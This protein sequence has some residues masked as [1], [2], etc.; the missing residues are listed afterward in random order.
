MR[1]PYEGFPQVAAEARPTPEVSTAAPPAAFGANTAAAL[2]HLGAGLERSGD[3]LFQRALAMQQ[4]HNQTEASEANVNFMI[5]AGKIHADY[6]ALQGKA[7]VDAYPKYAQDLKELQQKIGGGLSNPMARRMYDADSRSTM[8]RTI[9]NG[10]GHAASQQK[11]WAIGTAKATIDLNAKAAS[12]DPSDDVGFQ[13]KLNRVHQSTA[14]LA[15][16]HGYDEGSAGER[17]MQMEA[18]SKLWAQRI[19]GMSRTAPFEAAGMLDKHAK[20]MT[21]ADRLKVDAS[22]RGSARAVGS[23]NIANDVYAAGRET[24]TTPGKT[25]AQMEDE[26]R[27]KAKALSPDD[28]ILAQHAVAALQGVF[29]QDK[30]AQAQEKYNNTQVIADGIQQGVKNVQELRADPKVAAAIDALPKADQLKIPGQ[31]NNFNAARDKQGNEDNFRRLLGTAEADPEQFMNTDVMSEK[32]NQAQ[33]QTLRKMQQKMRENPGGDPRVRSALNQIRGAR[34]AEMEA[35]GVY[36][37][38]EANKDDYDKFVGAL[39]QSLE[40]WR[41]QNGRTPNYKEITE[42]IAPNVMRQIATP[43]AIF[44]SWWPSKNPA[45]MQEPPAEWSASITERVRAAGGDA[46]TPQ[47]LQRAYMRE[48][49]QKL[50]AKPPKA[51]TSRVPGG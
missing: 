51:D 11:Q 34:G 3:E 31:I 43:G 33:M 39:Q 35:L 4:L 40:V 1:V 21:E 27:A 42:T 6:G 24:E 46:P 5:E 8:A 38:T 2:S 14:E 49:F 13:D 48:Q 41:E 32:L 30:R 16:L 47:Q 19:I 37:R 22:V 23:V 20:E 36:S 7:A 45:F 12:D 50:Y 44:G 17:D 25:L 15:G 29:N 28:P 10:A 18:K 9:F 26:V